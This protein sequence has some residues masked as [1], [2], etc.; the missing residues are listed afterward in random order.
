[1]RDR[2][3]HYDPTQPTPIERLY[4]ISAQDPVRDDSDNFV[5]AVRHYGVSGFDKGPASVGHVVYEDGYFVADVADEDHAGDFVG[6]VAFFVD[7]SEVEVEAV[8]DGGCSGISS[9][10][11]ALCARF[12]GSQ[13]RV[14][15]GFM[16]T[17]LR[18]RHQG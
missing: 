1:M 17:S 8:G 12:K 9:A 4:R 11:S 10:G 3:R 18:P 16:H 2:V 7:E 13:H 15:S 14:G 5:C 6:T